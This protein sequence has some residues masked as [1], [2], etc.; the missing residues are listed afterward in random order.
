LTDGG[1]SAWLVRRTWF[2]WKWAV[3]LRERKLRVHAAAELIAGELGASAEILRRPFYRRDMSSRPTLHLD[4]W[5]QQR[6]Q[7]YPIAKKEPQLWA[8]VQSAY[9]AFKGPYDEWPEADAVEQLAARLRANA[10]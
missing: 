6:A 2:F 3:L 7:L 4:A 1:L 10:F 5:E 8:D 9:M